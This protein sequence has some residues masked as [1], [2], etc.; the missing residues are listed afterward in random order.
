MQ[1]VSLAFVVDDSAAIALKKT[2]ELRHSSLLVGPPM[3]E[4]KRHVR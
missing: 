4:R 1:K 2:P 3:A